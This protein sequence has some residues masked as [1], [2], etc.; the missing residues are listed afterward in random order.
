MSFDLD[1]Y[2]T[3]IRAISNRELISRTAR[4]VLNAAI[5]AGFRVNDGR[6][7]DMCDALY[8]E[9]V[10]RENVDLYTRGVN[11]AARSQGHG[12]L[13]GVARTPIDVGDPTLTAA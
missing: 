1:A 7:D 10:R 3:E 4:E 5:M 9:A 6:H 2:R 12:D 11:D 8:A 13:G